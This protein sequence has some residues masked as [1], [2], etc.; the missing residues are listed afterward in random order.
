MDK[1]LDPTLQPW[2]QELNATL[3]RIQSL[4]AT[5]Q[6]DAV[7]LLAILRSLEDMHRYI[8]ETWF[9]DS[10][11]NNRQAL[12]TLL[13]DMETEG[14][15]P[16]ISRVQLQT[17]LRVWFQAEVIRNLPKSLESEPLDEP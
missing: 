6:K 3:E 9:Q 8:R 11:P 14:G 17:I 12:Y 13:R 16:Y 2:E 5:H 7:T 10:L 4:A 15:W 1:D